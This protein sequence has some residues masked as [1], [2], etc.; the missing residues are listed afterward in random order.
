M[1]RVVVTGMGLLTPI[2]NTLDVF[3]K[4]SINGVVGYDYLDE[5][6]E[7]NLKS[8]V[9][10]KIPD[11]EF[12]GNTAI[13][14]MREKMGRATLLS[15]NAATRAVED[16]KIN[17]EKL[18]R[19]RAGVCIGNAIAD[20]PFSEKTFVESIDENGNLNKN[21]K[22]SSAYKK[23]M[24]S[25]IASEIADEF[26]LQGQCFVMS[27]GCTGGIDAIGYGYE[28]I[29]CNE[30]DIM[31]CGA[32]EAPI[33]SMT[34]VSFDSVGALTH[35]YNDNPKKASRPFD[36][37]RSGFVL[38]EG[39]G[40]VILEELEHALKRGAKIY[41]EIVGFATSN[42]AY[43][44][45][46]LPKNGI[47]LDFAMNLAIQ[48]S[49]PKI[50]K[51]S[52]DYINAH[53]SST[54]Q[55]DYFETVAYKNVFGDL[56]YKIPISSTKSMVGHPLSAA[57]AIGIVQCLL[58]IN[59]G[60]IP[61]TVNQEFPDSECDLNYVPNKAIKKDLS[62]VMTTASGFSGIHSAM[63]LGKN[64]FCNCIN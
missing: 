9:V 33:T 32:S 35:E 37:K 17:F 41:G 56:A 16:A 21:S 7:L 62:F 34:I 18:D 52:I 42:N 63:I 19:Q 55:N 29:L 44:M 57:S 4:N 25:F 30:H 38:S 24:F 54:K 49:N 27:T 45:T 1:R 48:N 8:K 46:D 22:D 13:K 51:S 26:D 39:C 50:K 36:S 47:G 64:E 59:K 28:S 20:T 58:A 11:F 10:G 40:I 43:H 6:N 31:I 60:V 61:P 2:G 12:K 14:E 3:W 53:G 5:F 15:V 23:G